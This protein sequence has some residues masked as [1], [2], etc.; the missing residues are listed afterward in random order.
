MIPEPYGILIAGAV[1]ASA[2]MAVLYLVQLRTRDAGIVDVAWAAL[3][4]VLAVVYAVY[5][6]GY[7]PRRILVAFLGAL[8]AFR[9]AGYLLVDRVLRADAED[10]RYRMLRESWGDRAQAYFFVF[11][12]VQAFF[13]IAFALPFFL[14]SINPHPALTAWDFAGLGVW[15]IAVLGESTAD[16]QLAR[17]RRDPAN[18]GKTCRAGLWRYSRHPNYFFEW[19]HWWAYVLISAQSPYGWAALFAPLFMLFLLFYVTGIPYTEKRAL[20]SRGEEYRQYQR[21]TSAFVPWF[22]K[23]EAV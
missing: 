1:L 12:Q 17:F 14:A 18:R 4:G 13:V 8:W 16:R 6:T 7:L 5:G 20:A 11:F 22:P 9:L 2:V 10:G 3:I 19:L 23:R 15:V 21:T